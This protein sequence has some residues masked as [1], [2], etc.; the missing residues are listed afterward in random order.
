[1]S[2]YFQGIDSS[3]WAS[4]NAQSKN[5]RETSNAWTQYILQCTK[6]IYINLYN[7]FPNL[8]L[9]ARPDFE[10]PMSCIYV[11]PATPLRRHCLA[12]T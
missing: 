10:L 2:L 12:N 3:Q 1:M 11:R 8:H 4:D 7:Q 6:T 5:V 9:D